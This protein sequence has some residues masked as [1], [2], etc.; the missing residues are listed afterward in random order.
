[1][2]YVLVLCTFFSIIPL[3]YVFSQIDGGS[4]L[5]IKVRWSQKLL[6]QDG[7]YTLTIPYSFPEFVTPAGKKMAKKERIKI[8]VNAGPGT[9]ILC[10]TISHPLKVQVYK[11]FSFSISWF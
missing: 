4:N 6:Y 1:M 2:A 5:T 10:K 7:Q 11:D 3:L 9:E 8:N